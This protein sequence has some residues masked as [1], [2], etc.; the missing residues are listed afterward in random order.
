VI[1]YLPEFRMHDPWVTREF[2]IRDLLTHRSGL[3]PG[4]G[5][6]LMFPD[7][8]ATPADIIRA[9]RYLEPAS[10]FRSQFDY[11][12]LLYIV[13]GELVARV[14]GMPFEEFLEE[15]LLAPLGMRDCVA[16]PGR[17]GPRAELATPHV[18]VEDELETTTTR[19]TALVAAAGGITC[20][21]H[22]MAN[23]MSFLL[24]EGA[25]EDGE[26]LVSSEQFREL[27][28]P[29]TLL[30]APGY[31]VEHAGAYLNAYA[32]GWGVSTFYGEPMLSH[33]GGV[34][35]MTTFIAV[36]PQR[37]LAVFATNNQMSAAPRA[38]VYDLVDQFLRDSAPGAGKDWMEIFSATM[39]DRQAAADQAVA[40]A[41]ESRNADSTP[42]LP[43]EEYAG[44]YR[45][46]WYG[47]IRI[48]LADD[49]QL[50]FHSERNEPLQGP[51]EHFQYDT[52]VARW[53]D[54]RLVADAY[55]SFSLSPEGT[56]E[57][58]R[59]K[60]VSPATDFSYDFHDLDLRPV[61]TR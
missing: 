22:S 2:T 12:N 28:S 35:G 39:Q 33:G 18:V 46:E 34:W 57:G 49:G 60:A 3:P 41:W 1:D 23:W 19:V 27:V 37:N 48:S 5:D 24:S 51:L 59:M 53:T 58:I 4:A 25:A 36:L 15:R 21:A 31:L 17:A 43:L 45:D 13:A 50:W 61:E 26:R 7:G 42:S 6:L 38:V 11:D 47:D 9:L 16:S 14:A 10:S 44:T 29:V 20:S 32:L 40:T 30:P 56:I 52:F 54:R 8:D 55:V